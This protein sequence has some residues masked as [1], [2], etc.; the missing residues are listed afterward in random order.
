GFVPDHD[1]EVLR[2]LRRAGLVFVAKTNCPE[3][4][5]LGTTEPALH[6]PT[7]NPWALDRSP[8]G[9]SGGTA[10]LVAARAVPM[11]HGGDGGGSLRIPASM[12]GVFGF[13]ATRG[14]VP[15]GPDAGEHWGG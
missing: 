15:A 2:R 9:S 5:L 13:K 8:G 4:G 12:C 6:G 10:A 14:R 3:L 1:G 7:F 11:G